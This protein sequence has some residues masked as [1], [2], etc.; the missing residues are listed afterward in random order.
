MRS[1]SL[2]H[3]CARTA[4]ELIDKGDHHR[5]KGYLRRGLAEAENNEP[6]ETMRELLRDPDFRA[7]V[8][9]AHANPQSS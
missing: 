9:R 1:K 2:R 7:T 5:A 6:I 4:G 3:L 8:A